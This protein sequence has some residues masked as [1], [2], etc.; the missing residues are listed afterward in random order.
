[1]DGRVC[2]V[3]VVDAT[4]HAVKLRALVSAADSG[5]AWDLRVQVRER[6]LA[7][8]QRAHPESLPRD[9][10]VIP[11]ADVGTPGDRAA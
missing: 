11:D 3:Q 9:R 4:H 7:W 2:N 5:R 1:V 10:V 8:L 6:W